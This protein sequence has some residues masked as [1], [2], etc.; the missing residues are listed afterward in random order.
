MLQR[1]FL[2]LMVLCW[3]GLALADDNVACVQAFLADTAFDPGPVDGQWGRRTATAVEEFFAQAGR[4]VEGGLD[5]S[6]VAEICSVFTADTGGELKA[7][8]IYRRYAITIDE[9]LLAD[10]DP[11]FFDFASYEIASDANYSCRFTFFRIEPALNN[12]TISRAQGS[13]NIVG[14]T[15]NF[16]THFWSTG[17]L[18]GPEFLQEQSNL[19]LTASGM[20]VGRT[21]YFWRGIQQ[22]EVALEPSDAVLS[23][24]YQPNETAGFPLGRSLF[25]VPNEPFRGALELSGCREVD[26]NA[27]PAPQ[28]VA[29]EGRP[30]PLVVGVSEIVGGNRDNALN[31]DGKAGDIDLNFILIG[32]FDS[33]GRTNWLTFLFRDNLSRDEA[34]AVAQCRSAR[35][36]TWND[37]SIHA[38]LAFFRRPVGGWGA[39]DP[40]CL[41]EAL[42]PG[43]AE[44]FTYLLNSFQDIAIALDA[45]GFGGEEHEGLTAFLKQVAAG[46]LS[47][48][49]S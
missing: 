13:V 5:Q 18:D 38:E 1:V 40:T 3:P 39:N 9:D 29:T 10:I 45:D 27:A 23:D 22:G 28:R 32:H 34:E 24:E 42:P 35:T 8:G 31:I 46:D 43:I 11:T 2:A 6:N 47:V 21:P 4:S 26:A 48:G 19:K 44:E 12:E 20:V 36:Q 41:Q 17:G 30:L 15:L 7:M 33:S 49:N 37:G 16:G 25:D 14:G